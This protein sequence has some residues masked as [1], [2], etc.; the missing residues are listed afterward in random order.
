MPCHEPRAEWEGDVAKD[1]TEAA[2]LL[3]A[4]V[5]GAPSYLMVPRPILEWYARHL[6]VD[7]MVPAPILEWYARHLRVDLMVADDPSMPSVDPGPRESIIAEID[8]V[9][10]ALAVVQH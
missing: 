9:S 8:A 5:K 10:K 4:M 2:Q 1:G 7:L 3:C 6:R